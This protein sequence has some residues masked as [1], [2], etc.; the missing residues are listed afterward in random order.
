MTKTLIGVIITIIA[1]VGIGTVVVSQQKDKKPTQTSVSSA[2]EDHPA[3]G[4]DGHE[5]RVITKDEVATHNSKA[6]CWT[7]IDSN[8]YDL[9]SYVSGHSGGSEILRACGVDGSSLFNSRETASGQEV[10]SGSPHSSNAKSD[11][12][13]LHIGSVQQ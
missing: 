6:S 8:V 9:T 3:H 11:L 12:K 5:D 10:G 2:A 7:I 13:D 1:I 4:A